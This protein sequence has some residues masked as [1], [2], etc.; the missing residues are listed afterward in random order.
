MVTQPVAERGQH[1]VFEEDPQIVRQTD[2]VTL[3]MGFVQLWH[4]ETIPHGQTDLETRTT[5]A[6]E[7]ASTW[8]DNETR[9]TCVIQLWC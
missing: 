1:W 8:P 9:T 3:T 7:L 2:V 4:G 5:L 6:L